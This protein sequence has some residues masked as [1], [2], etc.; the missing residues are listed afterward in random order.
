MTLSVRPAPAASAAD[1]I[2]AVNA[3]DLDRA[4]AVLLQL[5][6]PLPPEALQA[7]G[8]LHMRRERWA[9]AAEA[10]AACPDADD[11]TRMQRLI[12]AN[13]AALQQ[14]R[15]QVYAV[16]CAAAPSDRFRVGL[17]RT[18]R[19]TVFWQVDDART[20]CLSPE[21]DPRTAVSRTLDQLREAFKHGSPILLAGIGDGYLAAAIVDR[22][23][24]LMFD[25]QQVIYICEPDP[26][27]VMACLMIHD[28][29]AA[30]G[31]ILHPRFRWH[32]GPDWLISLRN[33]LFE[34]FTWPFPHT[35]I[36]QGPSGTAVA[37]EATGLLTD[38]AA[39]ERKLQAENAAYYSALTAAELAAVMGP[40]PPRRPRALIL[41][42]RY[43]TV[44]QFSAR[45]AAEGFARNGWDARVSIETSDCQILSRLTLRK[46]VAD[47][48]PDVIFQINHLRHEHGD[49]F[50]PNLPFVCWI[51]D[52][53]PHLTRQ[54]TGALLG[55]RDFVLTNVVPTYTSLYG[56]PPRQCL[57]MPKLTRV[58]Q[59][60]ASWQSDGPDDLAYVSH[61]SEPPQ[62]TADRLVAS[63]RSS[64]DQRMV[65]TACQRL[66]DLYLRGQCIPTWHD[67]ERFLDQ[68]GLEL[69]L[70]IRLKQERDA[71]LRQQQPLSPAGP[72]LGRAGRRCPGSAP[73]YL[74]QRME[75]APDAGPPRP[76]H[77]ALRPGPGETH[78]HHAH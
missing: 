37:T 13:L 73:G 45:D 6:D 31:P 43:S 14:H 76:R 57:A 75:R 58:P 46:Q 20:V 2:D 66:I 34:D 63:Y 56:Y 68:V 44:L 64:S 59:R 77:R 50:P 47:F 42:T 32:I 74:R 49:V 3:N 19:L 29:T 22:S 40:N 25:R 53:M 71:L 62:V 36:R 26:A 24:R 70:S 33:E 39:M 41:T 67:L 35:S 7:A 51:Q 52:H 38:I 10:L 15:P 12:A 65:R 54:T 8:R 72:A 60:P 21:E 9:R 5:S 17:S 23:P 4:D 30:D 1:L 78:A 55:Q 61:A 69:R 16:L 11:T 18:Q 28:Y 48:K 27:L